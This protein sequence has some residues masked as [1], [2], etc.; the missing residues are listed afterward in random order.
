MKVRFPKLLFLKSKLFIGMVIGFILTF[1]SIYFFHAQVKRTSTNEYCENCHVHPQAIKSWKQ[2]AHYKT[3][4]GVVTNCVDCHLPPDGLEYLVE[5][6]K[7]GARDLYSF[8]FTD[9]SLIDW[10]AKSSLEHAA[11]FT[12]DDSCNRC[13]AELF[14]LELN[15]KGV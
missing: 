13:H 11:G 3:A 8:Y 12:F 9:T 5:K 1:F 2:G 10:E 4:S 6:S 14:P 15:S 7:A